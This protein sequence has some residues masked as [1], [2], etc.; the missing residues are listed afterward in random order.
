MPPTFK[1][2]TLGPPDDRIHKATPGDDRANFRS[3]T[4]MG[5][6]RATFMA[7]RPRVLVVPSPPLVPAPP[8]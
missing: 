3:A 2:P 6:S 4:S 5:F 7:N 8:Y 1:D